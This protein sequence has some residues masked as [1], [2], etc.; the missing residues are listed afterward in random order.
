ME[1]PSQGDVQAASFTIGGYD[2]ALP[3][4]FVV[5]YLVLAAPALWLVAPT[6]SIILSSL[7][8]GAALVWLS[9][10]DIKTFRLPDRLTL[11]LLAAGLGLCAVLEW[12]DIRWRIAAAAGAYASLVGIAW[13]YRRWRGRD[14]L[15]Q[16]DAKLLAASGAWLGIDGVPLALLAACLAALLVA[17]AAVAAGRMVTGETRLPFGPFLAGGTWLIWLYGAWM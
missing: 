10:N 8:L 3:V 14:G 16:G 13:L 4:V 1:R 17:L 11:P 5:L 9:I 15:G 6:R 12:D 7:L 2:R